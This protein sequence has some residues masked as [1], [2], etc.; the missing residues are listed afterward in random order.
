M[1]SRTASHAGSW[2]S[3]SKSKLSSQ[4]DDWLEQVPDSLAG[5]GEI[6]CSGARVIIAPHAGYA[7]SGPPAAWAYKSLDLSKAKRIFLLGPSHHVYL[8]GCALSQCS[9]YDTPLGSLTIDHATIE[10]LHR[11]GKFE[12]MSTQTDEE[13]HSLEMQLPYLY[14][15]LSRAFPSNPASFPPLI[16]ILVGATTPTAERSYGSLLSPYLRDPSSIFIISS[17]FCH[18]GLRFGY[19]YYLPHATVNTTNPAPS[20]GHSLKSS[21]R[22]PTSPAIHESIAVLDKMAMTAVEAGRHEDFLKVLRE[23]GNTVCGRHPIGVMM[24]AVEV[25]KKQDGLDESADQDGTAIAKER[26]KFRFVRY[27]RSSEAVKVGDSSV[28]Y[29]SAFAVL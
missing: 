25:L 1:T 27:E 24:A 6:P 21:S 18:W 26:G 14:K 29:A 28:S 19:T 4:L 2:Y 9:T 3:S 7:F 20:S 5:V 13:E 12:K 10:E 17:D 23:T 8:S 11:T 15:V 16:P 22:T